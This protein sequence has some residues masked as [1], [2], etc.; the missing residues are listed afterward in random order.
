MIRVFAAIV[1][2]VFFFLPAYAAPQ[3]AVDTS[4]A[5]VSEETKPAEEKLV[6]TVERKTGSRMPTRICRTQAQIELDR[7][8]AKD[9]MRSGERGRGAPETGAGF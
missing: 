1:L 8:R 7:E 3:G 6:C 4:K 9:A 2:S 5:P